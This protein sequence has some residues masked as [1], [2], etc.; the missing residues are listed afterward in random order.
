MSQQLRP[1]GKENGHGFSRKSSLVL[2]DRYSAK[3]KWA[4]LQPV[5]QFQKERWWK[6]VGKA[7]GRQTEWETERD[8]A[9]LC[10]KYINF[11]MLRNDERRPDWTGWGM[12]GERDWW[13]GGE[14]K[15]E[16]TKRKNVRER[17]NR[18][19]CQECQQ[20]EVQ[21]WWQKEPVVDKYGQKCE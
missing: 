4:T 9:D 5:N 17:E 19:P 11:R 1:A 18:P 14:I 20:Q 8:R 21:F 12:D 13:Q 15:E 7:E 10:V 3:T 16:E 2:H 6:T